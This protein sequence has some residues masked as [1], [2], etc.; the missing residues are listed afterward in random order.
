LRGT[1]RYGLL[2]FGGGGRQISPDRAATADN[3]HRHRMAAMAMKKKKK[4]KKAAKKESS[5]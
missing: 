2:D 3:S 1:S 4:A 5:K